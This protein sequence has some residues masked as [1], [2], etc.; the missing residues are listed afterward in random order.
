MTDSK[1]K[2]RPTA[3]TPRDTWTVRGVPLDAREAAKRAA[4]RSGQT[5]GEWLGDQIH[6]A[7]T[8]KL[9]EGPLVVQRGEDS[10]DA[11]KAIMERL[12][13]LES[14]SE[15]PPPRSFWRRFLGG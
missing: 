6:L 2:K 7:A 13:A 4:R 15:A 14:R 1:R 5:L 10:P 11:L 8:Q 9:S 12:E 3:G